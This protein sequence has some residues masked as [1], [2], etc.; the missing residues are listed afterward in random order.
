MQGLYGKLSHYNLS[1]A[2]ADRTI[3]GIGISDA[4]VYANAL[5]EKFNYINTHYHCAPYLDI[6]LQES[7]DQYLPIDFIVCNDVIE[8]TLLPP[9]EVIPKLYHSLQTNG[10]LIICA[11][12]YEIAE[13]IEKYPSLASFKV[14]E[15]GTGHKVVY[16]TKRGTTGE[17]LTPCFHGGPGRVLELRILSE[18]ALRRNLVSAGF[19]VSSVDESIQQHYGAWWPTRPDR[20]DIGAPAVGRPIICNKII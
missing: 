1:K 12:T 7:F 3:R 5:S 20:P 11:P 14:E 4:P 16:A 17:D 18:A 13:H 6:E 19:K 10:I 2:E 8:H 9:G 15:H